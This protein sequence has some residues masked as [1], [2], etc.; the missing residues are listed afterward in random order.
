MIQ[1]MN[2]DNTE[3]ITV[4][5]LKDALCFYKTDVY[6]LKKFKGRWGRTKRTSHKEG[7]FEIVSAFKKQGFHVISVA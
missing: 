2:S 3:F 1:L 7:F 5:N 4:H 6:T